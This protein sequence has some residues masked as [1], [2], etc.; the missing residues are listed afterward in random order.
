[1]L[2]PPRLGRDAL[3]CSL[4][5]LFPTKALSSLIWEMSFDGG[6]L[7]EKMEVDYRKRLVSQN[8]NWLGRKHILLWHTY[9]LADWGINDLEVSFNCSPINQS[10][11]LSLRNIMSFYLEMEMMSLSLGVW[12]WE[13]RHWSQ[14]SLLL[15]ALPSSLD[16]FPH[17]QPH[18]H[19]HVHTHGH[20]LTHT[21][22]CRHGHKCTC[23]HIIPRRLVCPPHET[24]CHFQK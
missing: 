2:H 3:K 22:V 23:T 18:T 12:K 11:S 8:K 10:D 4:H 13:P 24:M 16:S 9:H 5:F 6:L 1:M 15:S 19:Q 20:M 17:M 14:G 7:R 21:C